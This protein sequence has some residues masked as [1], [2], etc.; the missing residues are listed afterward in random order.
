M[1]SQ[2]ANQKGSQKNS[3]NP[4]RL[5]LCLCWIVY[6]GMICTSGGLSSY[7]AVWQHSLVL[8]ASAVFVALT[9]LS[10]WGSVA[11]HEA[12]HE[13]THEH[14][15]HQHKV[16]ID[17]VIQTLIHCLPLFLIAG[18]G[19]TSL[20]GQA[21]ANSGFRTPTSN[22]KPLA[23]D[24]V[25]PSEFDLA[26][27]YSGRPLPHSVTLSGM[28]YTPSDEDYARLP[29]GTTKELMPVLLY[30][31]QVTCC[32]ADASPIHVGLSNVDRARFPND[33]WIRISGTLTAPTPPANVG[34]IHVTSAEIIPEPSEPYLKRSF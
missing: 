19:V 28:S 17:Q 15:Q 23:E 8:V 26:D 18:L 30:R 11:A 22:S 34:L 25:N 2:K 20:G 16:P 32:A 7:I 33:T 21:F 13:Q 3:Q 5:L 6:L 27:V 12:Q 29:S 14:H 24:P 4:D 9:L 1:T 31:Y 10:W